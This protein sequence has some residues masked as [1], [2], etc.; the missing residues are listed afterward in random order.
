MLRIKPLRLAGGYRGACS[1][2]PAR[3]KPRPGFVA[4]ASAVPAPSASALSGR[5]C[6]LP[7]ACAVG[8]IAGP[9]LR[10]LRRATPVRGA[11]APVA[12]TLVWGKSASPI[13]H[14][15]GLC[16]VQAVANK[17]GLVLAPLRPAASAPFG[18][19][20]P[21][22][23]LAPQPSYRNVRFAH[24][25]QQPDWRTRACAPVRW[26]GQA[27]CAWWSVVPPPA[28]RVCLRRLALRCSFPPRQPRCP[29]APE[30]LPQ[31]LGA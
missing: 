23:C 17:V 24:V 2:T 10:R 16:K 15:A 9:R 11:R 22:L 20:Q 31:N 25:A 6:V 14:N 21:A 26:P 18:F 28:Q 1:T 29:S 7:A 5:G 8:H 27:L 30:G 12:R 3:E 19:A 13:K 4:P